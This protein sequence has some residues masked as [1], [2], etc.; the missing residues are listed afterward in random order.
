MQFMSYKTYLRAREIAQLVKHL[1][2]KQ[3]Y[4]SSIRRTL[5]TRA[6]VVAHTYMVE[7]QAQSG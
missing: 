3:K 2:C 1:T 4:P 7:M 6:G 5:Y